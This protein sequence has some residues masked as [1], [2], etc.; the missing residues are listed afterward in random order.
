[1]HYSLWLLNG[2]PPQSMFIETPQEVHAA[3]TTLRYATFSKQETL[4]SNIPTQDSIT[5]AFK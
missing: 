2:L 1:M 4:L 3:F 5:E